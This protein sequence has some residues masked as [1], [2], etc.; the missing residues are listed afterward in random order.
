[1]R[2]KDLQT[3]HFIGIGGIGMSG[4]A[5]MMRARGIAVG[6]SDTHETELTRALEEEGIAVAIG[7]DARLVHRDIDL[8]V[9]TAAVS[10]DNVEYERAQEIGIP[11]LSRGSFLGMVSEEYTTVAVAGTHGKTTTSAMAVE[12]LEEAKCL[13][14]ALI[15]SLMRKHKSNFVSGRGKLLVVEACEYKREFLELQPTILII[16]NI[17]EDHLDYY[18]D[19]A[20][21]EDAF[22]ELVKKLPKGGTLISDLRIASVARV[23]QHAPCRVVDYSSLSTHGL[24]LPMPGAHN[25]LNAQA[26]LALGSVLG[27]ER[28]VAVAALNGYHGTSRRFEYKGKVTNNG[29]D[30]YDDYAH[31]PT[32]VSCTLA[33]ARERMPER[34]IYVVFQPHLFSRTQQFLRGFAESFSAADQVLFVPIYA[35]REKDNHIVSSEDLAREAKRHHQNARLVASLSEAEKYLR[36]AA[37]E[38]DVIITMGAGDISALGESLTKKQASLRSDRA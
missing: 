17:E 34:T 6:G 15:G 21:I 1:M 23:A 37:G 31:H 3:I 19:L 2:L 12:M 24:E 8:V 14:S 36:E 9:Y 29:A 38:G 16:T 35:A 5:R 22:A 11:L 26:A 18:R 7:H 10:P 4:L 20:D 27:I 33:G 30:V 32:A 28:D 25:V 13:P